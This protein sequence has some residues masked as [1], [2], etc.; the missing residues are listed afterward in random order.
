MLGIQISPTGE[1]APDKESILEQR[2]QRNLP[3]SSLYLWW[4]PECFSIESHGEE[5]EL[6]QKKS[7]HNK[8]DLLKEVYRIADEEGT[9]VE[10]VLA[11]LIK[12]MMAEEEHKRI[13]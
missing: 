2:G 11:S 9:S 8:E 3:L 4:L 1:E 13:R 10:R 12:K 5:R 6:N 7:P